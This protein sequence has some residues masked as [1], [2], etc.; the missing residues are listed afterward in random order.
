[1]LLNYKL[2][3]KNK[4]AAVSNIPSRKISLWDNV[5]KKKKKKIDEKK[6]HQNRHAWSTVVI[7]G[8]V[9]PVAT[10]NC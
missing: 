5:K 6:N 8:L 10:L 2:F 7:S 4:L 1:M 3:K 9:L